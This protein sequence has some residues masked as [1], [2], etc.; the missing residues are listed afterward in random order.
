MQKANKLLVFILITLLAILYFIF[1]RSRDV[2]SNQNHDIEGK[3]KSQIQNSQ[4][5]RPTAD[6]QAQQADAAKT[7]LQNTNSSMSDNGHSD[8]AKVNRDQLLAELLKKDKVNQNDLM[9]IA[10]SDLIAWVQLF[11][12]N[13]LGLKANELILLNQIGQVLFVRHPDDIKIIKLSLLAQ[14]K[15]YNT[16]DMLPGGHLYPLVYRGYQLDSNDETFRT[17]YLAALSQNKDS[18]NELKD[19]YLQ[20]SNISIYAFFMAYYCWN[21]KTKDESLFYL[22]QAVD[23]DQG[24]SYFSEILE[25]INKHSE[26]KAGDSDY[27]FFRIKY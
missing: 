5:N 7:Q 27:F 23:L 22:R 3:S 19:L 6:S 13:N 21:F 8:S 16:K 15:D 12:A 20:N 14:S 18:F 2:D 24:R 4:E 26:S 10:D 9:N 1:G 17:Q 25:K 11:V